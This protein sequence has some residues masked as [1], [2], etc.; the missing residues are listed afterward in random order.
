MLGIRTSP[1]I[2]LIGTDKPGVEITAIADLKLSNPCFTFIPA[3]P[4]E[5]KYSTIPKNSKGVIE[6][7]NSAIYR[8]K[9]IFANKETLQQQEAEFWVKRRDFDKFFK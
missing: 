9:F 7:I 1:Y 4:D 8:L 5:L 6:E 2:Q 3:A